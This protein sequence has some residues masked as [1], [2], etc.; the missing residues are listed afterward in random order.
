MA[1]KKQNYQFQKLKMCK[2]CQRY[3]ILKDEICPVCGKH[4]KK[5]CTFVKKSFIKRLMTEL[6]WILTITGLGIIFAP[7][8]QTMYY[9]S[10]GCAF[11]I[12]YIV[13]LSFFLKSEYYCQLKK[14]LRKDLR[15]IQAGIRFDSDLAEAEVKEGKVEEAYEKW[16]EIGEFV[17]SDAVKIRQVRVLN[18]LPLKNGLERELE[19]LI[20]SS[21]DRDF[22]KYALRML[23]LNRARISKKCIA[24]LICYRGNI[25]IDFGRDSL[26]AIA[27]TALRMKLYIL[28]FSSFIEEFLEDLPKERLLRLCSMIHTYPHHEWGSLKMSTT[29]LV[30]R[31]YSYD[32]NFKRFL[33]QKKLSSHA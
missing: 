32:P 6:M 22:V 9:L 17:F 5:V 28:E 31:N 23:N 15:N 24:Y 16:R 3:S 19:R 7:A 12:S 13:I 20:P 26:I 25:E 14:R 10:G 30:E 4:Y 2:K 27:D 33:E 1:K 29:R 21:Y 18:K 11:G 8:K